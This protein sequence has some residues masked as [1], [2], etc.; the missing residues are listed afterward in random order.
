MSHQPDQLAAAYL[1]GLR[2][3]PR[4]RYEQHLLDCEACWREVTLARLGRDLAERVT[5]TTPPG[6]REAIRAAVTAA[7]TEDQPITDRR[8]RRRLV[9]TAGLLAALLALGGSLTAWRPWQTTTANTTTADTTVAAAVASFQAD[10]LPGTA[11]PAQQPPDL[12][13]LRLHLIGA[14]TGTL[15]GTPVT[16]FAYRSDTGSRLHLY[17]GSRPIPGP[18]KPKNSTE[19]RKHGAP[20]STASPSS[21][22]HKTTPNCYSAQTPSSSTPPA[23][24]S[25]SSRPRRAARPP[26]ADDLRTDLLEP[27]RMNTPRPAAATIHN[28]NRRRR[29]R[30]RDLLRRS[31]T[32]DARRHRRCPH[33][34]RDLGPNPRHRRRRARLHR[35][36]HTPALVRA[37]GCCAPSSSG[38]S[39]PATVHL[40]VRVS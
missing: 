34:R 32:G 8:R 7:A 4:R 17:R 16:V 1:N 28:R 5:D 18:T 25:T 3:R 37:F 14:S 2:G 35:R 40:G 19:P 38:A 20:N 21:A 27:A 31:T 30:M 9:L 12:D 13:A 22:A 29:R 11:V 6:T 10:R 36:V 26:S 33:P 39:K 15:N 24:C 23:P